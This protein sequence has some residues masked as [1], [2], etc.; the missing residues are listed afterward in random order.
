MTRIASIITRS[1]SEGFRV[2]KL[3]PRSRFAFQ[4]GQALVI[5]LLTA[6]TSAAAEQ[7][8][9]AKLNWSNGDQLAGELVGDGTHLQWQAPVFTAPFII[10]MKQLHRCVSRWTKNCRRPMN[11][12]ASSHIQAMS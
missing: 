2:V 12:F 9:V 4:F 3:F 5:L 8:E 1:V 7:A 6:S 10:D 11:R